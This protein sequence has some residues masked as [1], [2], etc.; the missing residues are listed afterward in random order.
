[1]EAHRGKLATIL[2]DRV[3][4]LA[5]DIIA[6]K[7][8]SSEKEPDFLAQ[9]LQEIEADFAVKYSALK[10]SLRESTGIGHTYLFLNNPYAHLS[11]ILTTKMKL[12]P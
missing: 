6:A 12:E 7:L 1:M 9:Q 8:N 4:L 10:V 3:A 2:G 5:S 11:S